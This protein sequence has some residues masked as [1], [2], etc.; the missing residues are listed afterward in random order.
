MALPANAAVRGWCGFWITVS[1][2]DGI[3]AK[4]R[5]PVVNTRVRRVIWTACPVPLLRIHQ[6]DDVMGETKEG[7]QNPVER[8]L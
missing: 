4:D 7:T 2:C 8:A 6:H 1:F 5:V 3:R